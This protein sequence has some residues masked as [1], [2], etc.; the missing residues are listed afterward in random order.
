MSWNVHHDIAIGHSDGTGPGEDDDNRRTRGQ[1]VKVT[2]RWMVTALGEGPR[3]QHFAPPGSEQWHDADGWPMGWYARCGTRAMAAS[4]EFRHR[5]PVC[6]A[7]AGACNRRMCDFQ[8]L[9]SDG[10]KTK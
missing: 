1:P 3:R 10:S 7:C 2:G 4:A 6:P 8:V 5:V 9:P